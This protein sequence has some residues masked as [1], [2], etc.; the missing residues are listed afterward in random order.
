MTLPRLPRTLPNRTAQNTHCP[1][2]TERTIC[3]A[4]H[5]DAPI[6]LAGL[7]AL[8]VEISTNRSTPVARAASARF[9]VPMTLVR[10]ASSGWSSRMSTCLWA[11]AWNTTSGRCRMNTERTRSW[12]RMSARAIWASLPGGSSVIRSWRCVSS[13]SRSRTEAGSNRTICRAISAPIDP[14]APDTRT[15]RPRTIAATASRSVVTCCRPSR[16]SICRSRMSLAVTR[17]PT[18]SRIEGRTRRVTS[19]FSQSAATSRTTS[20]VAAGIV[21]RTCCTRRRRTRAGMADRLPRTGTPCNDSPS[22]FG[23]SS[24]MPTGTRPSEGL[25]RRSLRTMDPASPAP[26]SRTRL[27]SVSA[28]RRRKPNNRLWNRTAPKPMTERVAPRITTE[29]GTR[30]LPLNHRAVTSMT[31]PAKNPA[32]TTRRASCTL[33]Y[34]HIWP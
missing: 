7:T 18:V 34:R 9:A 1:S 30:R 2:G 33:A 16:S 23:S 13:W 25:R 20:L 19:A 21:N 15:R 5:L 12:S 11:A 31:T 14:P 32:S 22:F 17:P 27:D 26:T 6:T 29:S 28:V 10:R 4:N 8:S 3:S 24:T